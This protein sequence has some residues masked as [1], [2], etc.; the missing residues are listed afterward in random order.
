MVRAWG[1]FG[2]G[3]GRYRRY[4]CEPLTG[5]RHYFSVG[6]EGGRRRRSQA[7]QPECPGHHGSR[8]TRAGMYRRGS[9]QPRQRYECD[10]LGRCNAVCRAACRGKHTFTPALPRAHVRPGDSCAGLASGRMPRSVH[11][12]DAGDADRGR[13]SPCGPPRSAPG[14][15]D[16]ARRAQ[17][18]HGSG[19]GKPGDPRRA[20]RGPPR[21]ARQ[22]ERAP[23]LPVQPNASRASGAVP[24]DCLTCQTI[25][26]SMCHVQ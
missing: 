14:L 6:I 17:R 19:V 24:S 16:G 5:D 11:R 7:G 15:P 21:E 4:R 10:H 12:R 13:W 18:Q 26:I 2:R 20:V 22:P 3:A 9:A 25:N 23:P 1:T 8:V